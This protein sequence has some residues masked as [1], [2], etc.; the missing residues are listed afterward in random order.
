MSK[1]S[2]NQFASL[3]SCI[4]NLWSLIEIRSCRKAHTF[5]NLMFFCWKS[6]NIFL[7]LIHVLKGFL[8]FLFTPCPHPYSSNLHWPHSQRCARCTQSVCNQLFVSLNSTIESGQSI[9]KEYVFCCKHRHKTL[10][11]IFLQNIQ[12]SRPCL[13]GGFVDF[14][15]VSRSSMNN[16]EVPKSAE[17]GGAVS[18]S[19]NWQFI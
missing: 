1:S 13:T 19:E 7:E 16:T 10:T 17:L 9:C 18:I 4:C 3:K 2:G 14:L 8:C 15:V 12:N 6:C 11:L 5:E